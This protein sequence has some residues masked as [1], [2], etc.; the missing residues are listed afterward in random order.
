MSPTGP[1][2]V[3]LNI[4]WL[5]VTGFW[6]AAGY[7]VAGLIACILVVT[8]PF[9][10]AAFRTASYCLWPFGRRLVKRDDA[11]LGSGVG[12]VLWLVL[13]GWWLALGHLVSGIAFCLTIIGVPLGIASFK[14][15]PVSLLP[16]GREI[17]PADA[18]LT[19]TTLVRA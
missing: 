9:G 3:V 6:M 18:P 13:F 12:N 17:V 19:A 14:L 8:I 16:L 4:V 10:I 15:V 5:V 11:G 2:A 1:L 7:A